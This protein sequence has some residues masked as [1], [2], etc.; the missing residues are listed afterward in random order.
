MAK[1]EVLKPA[2]NYCADPSENQTLGAA[3]DKNAPPGDNG[4]VAE[5]TWTPTPLRFLRVR[6]N[7][8]CGDDYFHSDL[9]T[10]SGVWER[11]RKSEAGMVGGRERGRETGGESGKGKSGDVSVA[12]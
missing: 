12:V 11:G 6:A 5:W 4:E 7:G 2:A 3:R 1:Q 9:M 10:I 8:W